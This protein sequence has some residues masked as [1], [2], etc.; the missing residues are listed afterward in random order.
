VDNSNTFENSDQGNYYDSACWVR[1]YQIVPPDVPGPTM[2]DGGTLSMTQLR[3]MGRAFDIE[4]V[5]KRISALCRAVKAENPNRLS[6]ADA[7]ELE[8]YE[9][10]RSETEVL[11]KFLPDDQVPLSTTSF[12]PMVVVVPA[13]PE[14][15]V[16]Q[17]TA[18][19]PAALQ[20][21]LER[22]NEF[23][24]AIMADLEDIPN[25][26]GMKLMANVTNLE[27]GNRRNIILRMITNDFWNECMEFLNDPS[28]RPRLCVVGTP[29]IGKT[30]STAFPIRMLLK[31]NKTVVYLIRGERT[32]GWI[33]EFV[34]GRD[35]S[36]AVK[37]YPE[38]TSFTQI[39]SLDL[40]STF[41]IV[42]PGET[43]DSCLPGGLFAPKFMLVSS[44]DERHWGESELTKNR[45]NIK[46]GFIYFPVWDWEEIQSA[47]PYFLTNRAHQTED[48][49]LERFR[50]VGGVP[51]NTFMGRLDVLQQKQ[52]DAIN[53][54]TNDQ[55]I[56]IANKRLNVV[57]TFAVGQPRSAI[58][59]YAKGNTTKAK[60]ENRNVE[61]RSPLVAEKVYVKFVRDLWDQMVKGELIDS[62]KAFETYCRVL[63]T[64][65][66]QGFKHRL[67][68]GKNASAYQNFSFVVFEGCKEIRMV[69]DIVSAAK[70]HP[71]VLF[72]STDPQHPLYDFMYCSQN[73]TFHAFQAT[74]NKSH[75]PKSDALNMLREQLGT[76]PL[77]FYYMVPEEQFGSF[78]TDP[79]DP[80]GSLD[81]TTGWHIRVPKPSGN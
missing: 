60:F 30:T 78:V 28:H 53:A 50:K 37:V 18:T 43:K 7:A 14:K 36:V 12:E 34:P 68:I 38:I 45:D 2:D 26:N 69:S 61:I 73:G 3:A 70:K 22:A 64:R 40:N 24:K 23:A 10:M 39:S 72:H 62:P 77:K 65:P 52:D 44:P 5:P 4:P 71:L 48:E 66:Q 35:N 51:G 49:V 57:G 16:V 81:N 58:I 46:G 42:D 31:Q 6:H 76:S 47:R 41:F 27:T 75:K 59:G 11:T 20:S 54:L 32:D 1:L 55:V 29:G 67:C 63:I 56:D 9:P 17:A 33:Y 80:F 13:T 19:S 79:V 25:S 8:V 15:Q 74:I 21:A